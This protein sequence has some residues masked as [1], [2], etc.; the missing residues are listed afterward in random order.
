MNIPYSV[1]AFTVQKYR[2]TNKSKVF[3]KKE[4]EINTFRKTIKSNIGRK[5]FKSNTVRK[6]NVDSKI[7]SQKDRSTT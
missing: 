7:N 3:R 2:K 4:V 5:S 6:K 1:I